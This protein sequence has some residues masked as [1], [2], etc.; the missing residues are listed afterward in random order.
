MTQIYEARTRSVMAR[1][2]YLGMQAPRKLASCAQSFLDYL[3]EYT[4]Y[5]FIQDV[6][7]IREIDGELTKTF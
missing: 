1:A 2:C 3:V 4:L 5:V 6:K 7:R